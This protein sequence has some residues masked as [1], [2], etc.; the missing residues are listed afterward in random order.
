MHTLTDTELSNSTE[1]F[2]K[3][4]D[5]FI[6]LSK[7][8]RFL[9]NGARIAKNAAVAQQVSWSWVLTTLSLVSVLT[10]LVLST[11]V[12]LH[13]SNS[14]FEK[15]YVWQFAKIFLRCLWSKCRITSCHCFTQQQW[16]QSVLIV[17]LTTHSASLTTVLKIQDYQEKSNWTKSSTKFTIQC[18]CTTTTIPKWQMV[19]KI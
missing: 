12:L 5:V 1:C 2:N 3:Y 10:T 7:S 11:S 6:V 15:E 9:Y 13:T 4:I 17:Q 16:W 19:G 18:C 8:K 14:W